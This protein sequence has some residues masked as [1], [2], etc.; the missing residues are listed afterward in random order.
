MLRF[1]AQIAKISNRRKYPL[2][3]SRNKSLLHHNGLHVLIYAKFNFWW[4]KS[5]LLL[6]AQNDVKNNQI[7][8]MLYENIIE[9]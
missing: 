5:S 2:Y 3:G 4:A 1:E 9:T 8:I 7:L 6:G